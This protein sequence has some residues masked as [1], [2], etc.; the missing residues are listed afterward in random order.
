LAARAYAQGFC[1]LAWYEHSPF[2]ASLRGSAA[3]RDLLGRMSERQ[4]S[5]ARTYHDRWLG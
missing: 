5:L 2:L 1:C 4:Q 3:F